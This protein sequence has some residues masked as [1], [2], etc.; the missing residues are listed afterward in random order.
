MSKEVGVILRRSNRQMKL[1]R[2]CLLLLVLCCMSAYGQIKDQDVF[3]PMPAVLRAGLVE[4]LKLLIEYQRTQQW[5]K[6]YDLLS[7]AVTQ[8]NSKEEYVKR[9]RHWYTEVV[10]E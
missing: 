2:L 4:R 5:E 7:I 6:Q 1:R 3:A 10:P 8:G 9:N